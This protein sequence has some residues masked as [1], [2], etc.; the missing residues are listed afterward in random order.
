MPT[1]V[2]TRAG[3]SSSCAP[4]SGATSL[5]GAAVADLVVEQFPVGVVVADVVAVRGGRIGQFLGEPLVEGLA[6]LALGRR[7]PDVVHRPGTLGR[8]PA[9]VERI[10]DA[11]VFQC[12]LGV[13]H[14]RVLPDI[15]GIGIGLVDV[16]PPAVDAVHEYLQVVR[17]AVRHP[18]RRWV[19]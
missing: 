10:V 19:A 14:T 2:A 15:H 4:S 9:A 5:A 13:E 8:G 12:V 6:R 17:T 11:V 3:S 16:V 7:H 18:E 1:S